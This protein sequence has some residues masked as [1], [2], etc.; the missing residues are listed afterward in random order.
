[1]KRFDLSRRQMLRG[2]LA[3]GAVAMV[4]L[5]FLS[6]LAR[7]E[8][9]VFPTRFGVF[10]WGNGMVPNLWVP[11]QTGTGYTPSR[12]LAPL[13]RHQDIF[14]VFTGYEVKVPNITP[15]ES[16]KFGFLTGIDPNRTDAGGQRTDTARGPT[17]DQIAAQA[18]GEPTR[19][20]SIECGPDPARNISWNGPFSPNP[21]EGD[22]V[23]LYERLFGPTFREPGSDAPPDPR[24]ALRQSVLDVVVDHVKE[25]DGLLGTADRARLDQ[26]LTGIREVERQIAK[27]QLPPPD[28]EAC[29]KPEAPTGGGDRLA[30]HA[31]MAKLL[32]MAVA[33]D[34][35]RVFTYVYSTHNDSYV[36]PGQ[37]EGHHRLTHDE[38]GDQ[39]NVA[40]ITELLMGELAL[41][42]DELQA[43]PEGDETLLDHMAVLCTSDTSLGQVHGL[44]EYP[45]I[46]AGKANGALKPGQHIRTELSD[47]A[48]KIPLTALRSVGVRQA[49]FGEDDAYTEDDIG[50]VL[51]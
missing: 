5:P 37:T 35:T 1:M 48:S 31:V 16:G 4:P 45:A 21:T 41:F 15:H 38:L 24:L 44:F 33:C 8:E 29:V 10:N 34:Q 22:P 18:L 40:K 14:S 51:T 12:L 25:L 3:G 36:Y 19:F 17:V 26:H 42:L 47:T 28:L 46:L 30:K 20:R 7:A 13:A 11:E 32:A 27:L 23:A 2:L 39:P 49:S 50:E 6:S 9:G 43:I